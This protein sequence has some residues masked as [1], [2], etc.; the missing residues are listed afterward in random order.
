MKNL[1]VYCKE[2][3]KRTIKHKIDIKIES[4]NE[5]NSENIQKLRNKYQY[6]TKWDLILEVKARRRAGY[7]INQ[8]CEVLNIGN[9]SVINYN[10]I[11]ED[12]KEKYDKKSTFEM[13]LEINRKRKEELILEVKQYKERGYKISELEKEFN[14]N[15]RTIRKYLES[16]GTF[17]HS[18]IGI[19][20]ESKLDAYKKQ[21]ADL[22]NQGM[23]AAQIFAIIKGNG[24][25][26]S[27]SL[28]RHY[29]SKIHKQRVTTDNCETEKV[30]RKSVISLLYKDIEKIKFINK[31]QLSKVINCHPEL[32]TIYQTVKQFKEAVF[33]KNIS[34]LEKM[35][36]AFFRIAISSMR[37]VQY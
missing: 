6:E 20:R 14:L 32:D 33:S 13:K 31:E 25:E 24:Y 4:V 11:S 37:S 16:D 17:I 26:G 10:R 18:S 29:V 34:N 9:K 19:N 30:E 27:D 22:I 1:T 21:I 36:I 15:R 7:T 3:I 5:V 23:N 28:V 35:A 12:E 2:H 8:V